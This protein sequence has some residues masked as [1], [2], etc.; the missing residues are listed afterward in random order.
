MDIRIH[1]ILTGSIANGP[2]KR[3]AVW[4]QGCTLNCPGCFNP[5]THS[6]TEGFCIS[7]DELCTQLLHPVHPCSGITI[8]GGEPFQ[9]PDGLLELVIEL[10]KRNA[11][12]ILVFSGYTFQQLQQ[13]SKFKP[14]QQ[15]I[16][17]LICG[18]YLKDQ[19]PAYERFCSSANQ[20]LYLFSDRLKAEDFIN[21]PIGEIIID[22]FGN[23]SYS[24]LFSGKDWESQNR[25]E[26]KR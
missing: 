1:Q 2:G 25:P 22:N 26:Q 5:Q 13:N 8:S 10:K 9:Q 3:N 6:N 4:F 16:D 24:G 15:F 7:S 21:L 17:S 18:P 12:P 19:I 23:T 11:P 14:I 20:E